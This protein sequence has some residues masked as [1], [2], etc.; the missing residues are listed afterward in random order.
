M[1]RA[2]LDAPRTHALHKPFAQWLVSDSTPCPRCRG[3][4]AWDTGCEHCAERDARVRT[5]SAAR[6][7]LDLNSEATR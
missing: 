4:R 2:D 1:T 6:L 3:P 7:L 5:A